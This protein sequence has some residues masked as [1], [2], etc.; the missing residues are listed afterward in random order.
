[1]WD[2]CNVSNIVDLQS[3]GIQGANSR[4]TA[5][6]RS[7]YPNIYILQAVGLY[8]SFASTL[9]SNL[10]SEWCTLPGTTETGSTGSRPGQCVTLAICNSDNGVIKGRVNVGYTV[11]D[12]SP[13]FLATC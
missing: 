8:C 7:I 6:A 5:R 4:F 11:V 2:R 1:M 9:G 10:C 13:G 12:G 3:T